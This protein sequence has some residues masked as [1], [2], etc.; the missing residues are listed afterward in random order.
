MTPKALGW[1]VASIVTA[2]GGQVELFQVGDKVY[3]AGSIVWPGGNSAYHLV[4]ERIV[5]LRPNNLS[6]A[7]NLLKNKSVTSV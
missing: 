6:F 5:G 2:V 4:N 3:Y 7:L 1:D